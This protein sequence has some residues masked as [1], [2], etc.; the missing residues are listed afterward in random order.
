MH[1]LHHVNAGSAG[2]FVLVATDQ[3]EIIIR[4]APYDSSISP[5]S[6]S[7]RVVAKVE[8]CANN[9]LGGS[10][11]GVV[12]PL[13]LLAQTTY[14]AKSTPYDQPN[15]KLQEN[16]KTSSPSIVPYNYQSAEGSAV[17]AAYTHVLCTLCI[18]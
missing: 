10:P 8:E 7:Y 5:L 4:S 15:R 2:A 18:E 14:G 1:N 11:L 16:E 17:L 13:Q 3:P 9:I 12:G 6:I